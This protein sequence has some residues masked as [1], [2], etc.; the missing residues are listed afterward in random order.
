MTT[1]NCN[2]KLATFTKFNKP[3]FSVNNKHKGFQ[4]LLK[5]AN[6]VAETACFSFKPIY[7]KIINDRTFITIIVDKILC[8]NR[9]INLKDD[10]LG[11]TYEL[12]LTFRKTRNESGR[13][14]LNIYA[15]ELKKLDSPK[16]EIKG[17]VLSFE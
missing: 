5:V 7:S 2:A 13:Y 6:K 17:E 12:E 4:Q 14:F 9:L 15:T 16:Y 8:K 11:N 10:D 1:F 3:L